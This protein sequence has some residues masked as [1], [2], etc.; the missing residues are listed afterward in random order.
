[1]APLL[2]SS[3]TTNINCFRAAG[4]Q[5]QL[6]ESFHKSG[7]KVSAGG[8]GGCGHF[9]PPTWCWR[10]SALLTICWTHSLSS[11]LPVGWRRPSVLGSGGISTGQLPTWPLAFLRATERVREASIT[12]ARVFLKHKLK[13]TP[14]RRALF[15]RSKSL[16]PDHT[17]EGVNPEAG[18]FGSHLRSSEEP[19]C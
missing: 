6:S 15:I 4:V 8:G 19:Q 1:M 13:V 9:N 2:G 10:D 14:I 5:G 7:T 16:R 18:I 11:S 17:H 3:K 12:E